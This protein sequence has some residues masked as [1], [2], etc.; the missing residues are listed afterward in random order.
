MLKI[1]KLLFSLI[2]FSIFTSSLQA[3]KK[4]V[5]L[6]AGNYPPYQS[7]NLKYYGVVSKVIT[8][9]FALES[10]KVEYTFLP[11][12]RAYRYAVEGI[13]DGVGY[14]TK[15]KK[16]VELFYFSEP[17]FQKKRVF[18][19]LKNYE[20]DWTKIEDLKGIKIGAAS[21][22]SYSDEF[23]KADKDKLIST[24][25]VKSHK[26][27]IEKLLIGNRI[28]VVLTTIDQ[29]LYV[30]QTKH[31]DISN[32]VTYH[33]KLLHSPNMYLMLSKKK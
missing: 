10:I 30:L 23:D 14:A 26:Q 25:R 20:F 12:K 24:Y 22:Y 6:T 16:R 21:G 19:H 17:I 9:A 28:D 27:N 15:K 3:D 1:S 8:E 29:G 18:F 2:V 7:E 31:K 33:P 11:W 5:K 13:L 32:T 4:V